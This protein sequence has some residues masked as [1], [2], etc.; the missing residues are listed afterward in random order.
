MTTVENAPPPDKPDGEN[1]AAPRA[2]DWENP[3]VA[4]I[5][6][7]AAKCFARKGFS[8]TTLAE[9]GKELGLRKSIVHYYFASKAALI[10]EVQ[11]YTYHK[12]LDKV[13]DAIKGT[14]DSPGARATT[15]LQSLWD[16]IHTNKTGL[17][18]NIEV[19]S[20][21]RRDAELKRRAAV[22][23]RDARLLVAEAVGEVMGVRPADF[24]PLEAMSSLILA[25]ANGLSVAEYLEGEEAKSKEA[26]D[27]FLYL[28]RLGIKALPAGVKTG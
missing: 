18:L 17:G 23:Q 25:V 11:S 3:R 14:G 4:A 2:V 28:V 5:L 16:S 1:G 10:H 20:A 15:A 7:A 13:K 26:F 9:I 21:S 6:S 19:W 22:L 12:Y 24:P 27:Q 8:A